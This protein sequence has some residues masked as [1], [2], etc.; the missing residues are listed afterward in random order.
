L[1]NLLNSGSQDPH[2]IGR[3]TVDIH[4]MR[5]Q[6]PANNYRERAL[7]VLRPDQRAK[8]PALA[9]ALIT[10]PTAQAVMLNLIGLEA[11]SLPM[12]GIPPIMGPAGTRVVPSPQ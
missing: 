10:N 6:P 4:T 1:Y 11:V 5:T 3:L 12:P 9:Q 2:S 7:A 8:L